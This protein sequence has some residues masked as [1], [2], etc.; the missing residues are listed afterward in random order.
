ML[1]A[2][3]VDALSDMQHSKYN[4]HPIAFAYSAPKAL[5][6]WSTII[7]ATEI[8]SMVVEISGLSM[9]IAL[10]VVFG[11]LAL[12]VSLRIAVY[13]AR[14]LSTWLRR[15]RRHSSIV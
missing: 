4:F 1:R 13:Q 6:I 2:L 15:N 3:Q 5:V 10:A 14:K 12:F 11:T 9:R 7:L 8:F